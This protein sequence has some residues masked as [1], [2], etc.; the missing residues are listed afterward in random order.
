MCEAAADHRTATAL[1][2][3]V[4]G[5]PVETTGIDPTLDTDHRF[6]AWKGLDAHRGNWPSTRLHGKMPAF[7]KAAKKALLLF[8][9]KIKAVILMIDGDDDAPG[10][11]EALERARTESTTIP[12]ERIVVAVPQPER[13]AWH[14][15]AFEPN[16]ADEQQRLE[17]VR[18]KLGCDP[19]AN[20]HTLKH[21]RDTAK[22]NAKRVLEELTDRDSDR[23]HE[24]LQST[25]EHILRERGQENGLTHF[26]DGLQRLK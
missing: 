6:T 3:R 21:G 23:A 22:R 9:S 26:L 5:H 12:P 16:N 24:V 20:S 13:E 2:E 1:A 10:R 14:I 17:Q 7:T 25:G 4:L 18:S 11:G 15:A 19:R 8:P